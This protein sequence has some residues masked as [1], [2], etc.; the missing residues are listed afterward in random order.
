MAGD[1]VH[2]FPTAL[3][4]LALATCLGVLSGRV[5][6]LPRSATTADAPH[7]ALLLT[8]L[9]QRL[10][11]CIALLTVSSISE[12]MGRA[13]GMSG[14]PLSAI[15]PVLSTVLFRTHYGRVWLIRPVALAGLW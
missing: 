3:D 4:L 14:R 1:L 6:V 8:P 7:A 5:W 12:L 15:V 2:I 9:W 13:V 10:V 11:V